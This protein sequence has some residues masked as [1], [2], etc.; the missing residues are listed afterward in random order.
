MA[1]NFTLCFPIEKLSQTLQLPVLNGRYLA[2]KDQ[3]PTGTWTEVALGEL[4]AGINAALVHISTDIAV[5]FSVAV[6]APA[7]G[8][9]GSQIQPGGE[10]TVGISRGEKF[11]IK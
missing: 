5:R 1:A 11:W 6:T 4:P 9:V 2:T 8:D 10:R 3:A 7:G